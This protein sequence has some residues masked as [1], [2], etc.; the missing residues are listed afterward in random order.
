MRL[1]A[2]LL[3]VTSLILL[4]ALRPYARPED[5]LL[6][7]AAQ[8]SLVFLFIGAGYIRLFEEAKALENGPVLA[9]QLMGFDSSD[10]ITGLMLTFS[11]ATLGLLLLMTAQIVRR[12]GRVVVIRDAST[13]AS[14]HATRPRR[15]EQR[16]RRLGVLA[17]R[18]PSWRR[19]QQQQQQ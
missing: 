10:R 11:F 15:R 1:R 9:E 2:L 13:G 18:Y 16:R 6:A 14:E 7:A 12:E 19:R 8:A 5:N 4:L 17:R 3:S